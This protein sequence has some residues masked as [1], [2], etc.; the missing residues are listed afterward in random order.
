[1]GNGALG[2]P[3][4]TIPVATDT[5]LPLTMGEVPAGRR[6]P[7]QSASLPAFPEGEPSLE[8][9]CTTPKVE[10]SPFGG[11]AAPYSP[12]EWDSRCSSLFR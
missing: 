8:V 1:M 2:T 3:P 9:R 5:V 7:S 12:W 11:K 10:P 4:P 6:G